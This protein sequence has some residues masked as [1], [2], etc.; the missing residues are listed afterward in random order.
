MFDKIKESLPFGAF[1]SVALTLMFIW[2]G[3]IYLI[4]HLLDYDSEIKVFLTI[5]L[6]IVF[7]GIMGVI[8]RAVLC[9]IIEWAE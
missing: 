9:F 5:V 7:T 8:A 6:G 2:T 4:I 1:V 3:G